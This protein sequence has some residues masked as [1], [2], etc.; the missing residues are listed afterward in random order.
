MH[1][2]LVLSSGRENEPQHT[3]RSLFQAGLQDRCALVVPQEQVAEYDFDELP[4]YGCPANRIG[5]TRQWCV[6]RAASAGL[7]WFYMLDDDMKFYEQLDPG[8]PCMDLVDGTNS[9]G[10]CFAIMDKWHEEGLVHSTMMMRTNIRSKG[11]SHRGEGIY[12]IG[13]RANNFHGLRPNVLLEENIRYDELEVMEDFFVTLSLLKLGL[14]NYGMLRWVWNQR[15][16]GFRGG[17]SQ[18]RDAAMQ[19]RA[20]CE[21]HARFPEY[22]KLRKVQSLSNWDAMKQRWDVI[23]YWLRMV[24]DHCPE[25]LE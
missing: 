5:P 14:V 12:R 22:V 18:Y 7:K 13:A 11:Q 24:Q 16:S 2:I 23:I 3:L 19:E 1:D 9:L 8:S 25:D 6:E 4:V 21:L 20:A 15:G 17:C 10:E